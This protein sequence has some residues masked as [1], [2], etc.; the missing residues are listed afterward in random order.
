MT[1]NTRLS[2]PWLLINYLWMTSL[3]GLGVCS[4][5]G[6]TILRHRTQP[7][8]TYAAQLQR[9]V[10]SVNLLFYFRASLLIWPKA[11]FFGNFPFVSFNLL[12]LKLFF[13]SLFQIKNHKDDFQ[14]YLFWP[15][16]SQ[17][18]PRNIHSQLKQQ[19]LDGI[20]TRTSFNTSSYPTAAIQATEIFFKGKHFENFQNFSL[21]LKIKI[22]ETRIESK[23][24]NN[25]K[26]DVE[27]AFEESKES[28]STDD[29]IMINNPITQKTNMK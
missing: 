29:D 25:D 9:R 7:Q 6:R 15:K 3:E 28:I 4:K 23:Y 16:S 21:L 13:L 14:E 26:D 1:G 11:V 22:Q 8:V 2:L 19:E 12:Y 20:D 18:N 24:E 17:T 27:V 10:E 5:K